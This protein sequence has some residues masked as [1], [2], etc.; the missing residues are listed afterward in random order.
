MDFLKSLIRSTI[1]IFAITTISC[2]SSEA[3]DC[4]KTSGDLKVVTY[5]NLEQFNQ[6]VLY[7]N[8]ELEIIEADKEFFELSYGENLIPEI[9]MEYENDSLSF[10]NNNSCSWTR[11]FKKPTL[12][13]FT[14]RELLNIF[15]LSNGKIFSKD[16]IRKTIILRI[17]DASNEIEIKVNNTKTTLL[18]N[19]ISNFKLSGKSESLTIAAY[20]NDGIYDCE[21]LEVDKANILHRGYNDIIVNVKDKIEGS[22]ENA[23]RILYK[24][25]PTVDVKVSNGGELIHLD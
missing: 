7:N 14:N 8:I 2:N 23:G 10:Y 19:S 1:F 6:L 13:W 18:S 17:E 16:T 9:L 5:D 3:P 15:T 11:D 22:I 12:K 25:N 24:G 4:F 20:F 21:A